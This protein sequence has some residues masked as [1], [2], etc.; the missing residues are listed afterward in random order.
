MRHYLAMSGSSGCLPDHLQSCDDWQ[1]AVDDLT[2]LFELSEQ[3]TTMLQVHGI[4]A[5]DP[6]T[7]GADYCEIVAC[8][9]AASHLH[10]VA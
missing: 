7:D 5:L 6:T 2:G 1:E 9:C 8:D 4:L 3:A 10:E